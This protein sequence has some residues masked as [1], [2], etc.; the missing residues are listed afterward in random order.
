MEA[1][2][3]SQPLRGPCLDFLLRLAEAGTAIVYSTLLDVE[4]AETAVQL[5]L[6]ERHS[7]DWKRFRH[8]GRAKRRID[9]LLREAAEAWQDVAISLGATSVDIGE[10]CDSARRLMSRHGLASYDAV[11]VATALSCDVRDLVTIDAGFAHVPEEQL[12]VWVDA[13]RVAACRCR[14]A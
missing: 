13:S 4:L 10:I 2:V 8:D 14:R 7:R 6:K 12:T 1:L 5:A 11:H 3:G 9:R